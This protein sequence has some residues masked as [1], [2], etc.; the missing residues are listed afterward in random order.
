MVSGM[1][2]TEH[3]GDALVVIG[4]I[5]QDVRRHLQECERARLSLAIK[6]HLQTE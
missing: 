3:S 1:S 5:D 2:E 6:G 4:V